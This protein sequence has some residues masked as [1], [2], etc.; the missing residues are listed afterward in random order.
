MNAKNYTLLIKKL[1]LKWTVRSSGVRYFGSDPLQ[2]Y[3]VMIYWRLGNFIQPFLHSLAPHLV[4]WNRSLKMSCN[5]WYYI[6]DPVI[7]IVINNLTAKRSNYEKHL[8]IVDPF[9]SRSFNHQMAKKAESL[10]EGKATVTLLGL[11]DIPMIETR[12]GNANLTSSASSA[13]CSPWMP[14]GS[15]QS[16]TLLFQV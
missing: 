1:V 13:W 14:S 5:P 11:R 15:R 7:A 10:L 9:P 16:I 3:T 4:N 2:I 6:C 12:F 8:F